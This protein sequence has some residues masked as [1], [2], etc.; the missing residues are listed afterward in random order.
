MC[1]SRSNKQLSNC[2]ISKS[3][4]KNISIW[5]CIPNGFFP[6][7]VYDEVAFP[8]VDSI[9]QGYN[10]TVFVYG[11]IGCGKTF[12][13]MGIVSDPNLRAVIP[14]AFEYFFGFIKR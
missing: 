14:N 11:Q 3:R 7:K 6:K 12:T 4:Y 1:R 10:R 5:L 13:M 2:N 9:F 8:I